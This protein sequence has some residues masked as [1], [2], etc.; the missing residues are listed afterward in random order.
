[1]I[2]AAQNT[3]RDPWQKLLAV[4]YVMRTER[5]SQLGLKGV[6]TLLSRRNQHSGNLRR[7]NE[8]V[9]QSSWSVFESDSLRSDYASYKIC[10]AD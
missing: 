2:R 6:E 5:E 4:V 8:T 1:M 7:Y 10:K 9:T 3:S